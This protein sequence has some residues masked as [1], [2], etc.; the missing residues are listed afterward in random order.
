MLCEQK[1]RD[2]LSPMRHTK[3]KLLVAALGVAAMNYACQDKPMQTGN[4]MAPEPRPDAGAIQDTPP[5]VQDAGP[6]IMSG[7]LMAPP[8]PPPT[9]SPTATHRIPT[10]NLMPPPPPPSGKS[11]G[12]ISPVPPKK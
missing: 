7:N 2:T 5:N 1:A 6:M 3:K 8:P 10:G 9:N 11:S 4:L 12:P